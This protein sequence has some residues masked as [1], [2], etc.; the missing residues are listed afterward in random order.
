MCESYTDGMSPLQI[1]QHQRSHV[2]LVLSD[3][4]EG[5]RE[6][7]LSW[8]RGAYREEVARSAG[9]VGVGHY[10]QH[11]IDITAG[12]SPR[13]PCHYLGIYELS[14]DGA[15][16]AR[17]LIERVSQLHQEQAAAQPPAT[18]LYYPVS[19]KVGRASGGSAGLLT[20]AFAN[21]VEGREAEFREWYSTRHIRHALNVPALVSGQCYER[22][23]FQQPGALRA[24]FS[25]I[26]LYEQEGT[27]QSMLESFATLPESTFAFPA[28]DLSRFAEAVYRPV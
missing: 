13:P 4:Q 7:F 17:E 5:E 20:L 8:Y 28:M 9:V 19:E 25:M 22:T 1:L 24:S 14:V 16:G 23:Q 11:E 12:Q 15:E 10:E 26:A 18:W 21:A 6:A 27:P 3:E 2:L